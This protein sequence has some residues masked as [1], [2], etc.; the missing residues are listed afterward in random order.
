M[1]L[2]PWGDDEFKSVACRGVR[3]SLSRGLEAARPGIEFHFMILSRYV[4]VIQ[5]LA[6]RTVRIAFV[7]TISTAYNPCVL[8]VLVCI[9]RVADALGTGSYC[10]G[11]P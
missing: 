6:R 5:N 9:Q 11:F 3:A 2:G 10:A 1:C 4:T 7:G 8:L